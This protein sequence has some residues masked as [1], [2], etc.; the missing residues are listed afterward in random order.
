MALN[1]ELVVKEVAPFISETSARMQHST[2][3]LP[4]GCSQYRNFQSQTYDEFDI[5][6]VVSKAKCQKKLN[7]QTRF[8]KDGPNFVYFSI[9]D[10]DFFCHKVNN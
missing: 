6:I 5:I 7:G 2:K 8:C 1:F 10:Q 4:L 3:T 9:T